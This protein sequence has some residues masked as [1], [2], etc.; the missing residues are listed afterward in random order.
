MS[1]KILSWREEKDEALLSEAAE[2][3][4]RGG[5][6]AIPTETV[7]G[8][9]ADAANGEA[10]ARVFAA[11]GRPRF[12]PLIAHV[13]DMEMARRCARFDARAE[14]LASAFWPGPLTL[15][16]PLAEGAPVHELVTAGLDTIALRRPSGPSAGL[17]ARF[18]RPLAAP[19]ANVSGRLSPTSAEHVLEGLGE[20]IDAVIDAGP[21]RVGL[22]STIVSL[23]G[24]RP[25]LLR[26]GGLAASEVEAV[27]G[28][29][30]SAPEAVSGETRKIQAPGMLLS[31]Y[32][33]RAALRLGAERVGPGEALLAFG[34][35]L[36]EGAGAAVATR[37]LSP[38]GNLVEAAAN[39][40]AFLH[41]LD[42]SGASVIAV[43]PV[44]ERGL[45]AAINDRLAR[46]AA[47]RG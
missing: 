20:E 3:L 47:P 33:P 11:K 8:L 16:L 31:H 6:V 46:A 7:Y 17:I 10:V 42:R 45:G 28:E 13:A 5:L 4:A 2:I 24:D 39:L 38:A 32:A 36:P 19:S 12:N 34:P 26:S 43:A 29:R 1:A 14:K 30:L 41:D 35:D 21:C 9:A 44:P 22:E 23:A 25:L 27:L 37:N 40:F 18:G 15:V